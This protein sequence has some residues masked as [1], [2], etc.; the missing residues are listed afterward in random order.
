MFSGFSQFEDFLTVVFVLKMGNLLVNC[1]YFNRLLI[2]DV[3][4]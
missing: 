2:S 3:I 1:N 4:L